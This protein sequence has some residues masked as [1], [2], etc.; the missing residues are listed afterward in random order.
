M[1]AQARPIVRARL[2]RISHWLLVLA[3]GLLWTT[4]AALAADATVLVASGAVNRVR[5]AADGTRTAV[6]LRASDEL[7]QGD[8]VQTMA[9]G[10]AQLRFTDGAIISLQPGTEFRIDEY[11]Y[12]GQQQRGFFTLLR[13]ALRTATGAIGKRDRDDYRMQTPTA[14]IGI[15]GTDYV[16]EQ[17]V[18]DPRCSPGPAAG[19]RVAVNE[20][21]IVLTSRGGSLELGRGQAAR[22]TSPDAAPSL[23]RARPVLS[24]PSNLRPRS[25]AP[26]AA[27]AMA[28]G[29]AGSQQAA[30][31]SR[32]AGDRTTSPVAWST[33]FGGVASATGATASATPPSR[34]GRPA[35]DDEAGGDTGATAA[36][37]DTLPTGPA[38]A[39]DQPA[40]TSPNN[41][42]LPS[43][44]LV[45]AVTSGTGGAGGT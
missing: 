8:L 10:R 43:G 14:T 22:V 37:K 24:P 33:A 35:R 5:I 6:R 34:G 45:A 31:G 17:T 21:R 38:I 27:P 11:R 32:D 3:A 4:G 39:G 41:S 25:E 19:L 23:T 30:G 26:D 13:G 36:A 12:D 9:D 20:G 2:L 15:R 42:R 40:L 7:S 16:A 18:C 29:S 44:E 28:E 1:T